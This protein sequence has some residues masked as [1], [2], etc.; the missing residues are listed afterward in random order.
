MVNT[1]IGQTDVQELASLRFPITGRHLVN[2]LSIGLIGVAIAAGGL[3]IV[4]DG[5]P[6]IWPAYLVAFAFVLSISL[7]S[8]FFVLVQH[9]TRAGWSVVIRRPAEVF[10]VNLI[11]VAVLFIPIAWTVYRGDDRI[12]SWAG[13]PSN[14]ETANADAAETKNDGKTERQALSTS[15]AM[16]R[17]SL[18]VPVSQVS[19]DPHAADHSTHDSPKPYLTPKRFLA[20]W[21]VYFVIWIGIACFYFFS[22]VRQDKSSN[23]NLTRRMEWCSG[24]CA[25]LFALALTYGAFD[26]LMSLD[27]MWYSTIFGVY[28]FAGCAV[29]GLAI[30][31][32]SV[33]I[34]QKFEAPM[35]NAVSEE[36]QR[37]LG[38]LLFAFVFFWAYIAFSQYM[39]LWYANVPETTEWLVRR[40]MSTATGY[41]NSWGW[42]AIALLFANFAIPFVG[43]MSRHVKSN[44]N[45]MIFWTIW[46]LVIHFLDLYWIVIPQWNPEFTISFIELGIAI[47]MIA[48][49]LFSA[50]II[51]S[52]CCLIP[53]GDP[54]I[55]ESLKRQALY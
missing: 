51:A 31:M 46:L 15:Q 33:L 1:D 28:F 43:F 25:V 27:P 40:G 36:V 13:L 49:Y 30:L 39:L 47:A 12:Y 5:W 3:L 35:R 8:L 14:H 24:L 26:L 37:D 45:A 19:T 10:S 41:R 2:L 32:L 23:A 55:S 48:V 53:V 17:E 11:L 44:S 42:L 29:A 4:E 50:G 21:V 7:G 52:S 34:L 54:R 38:R 6:R 18:H 9:L 22:S 16:T 20:S